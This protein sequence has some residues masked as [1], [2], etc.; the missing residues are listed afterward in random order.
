L[1]NKNG[2]PVQS[3]GFLNGHLPLLPRGVFDYTNE[4]H[5]D[6][7]TWQPQHGV[8]MAMVVEALNPPQIGFVTVGRSLREIEKR[9]SNLRTMIAFAWLVC[10]GIIV[11][12]FLLTGFSEGKKSVNSKI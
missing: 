1:Y 8:R 3:S 4:H 12:H 6:I 7:L 2:E 10:F 11:L 9:E 5:E